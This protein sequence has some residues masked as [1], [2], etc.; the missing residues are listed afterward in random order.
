MWLHKIEGEELGPIDDLRDGAHGMSKQGSMAS[1]MVSI[2][3]DAQWL[4]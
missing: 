2:H 3:K 4:S 1:R